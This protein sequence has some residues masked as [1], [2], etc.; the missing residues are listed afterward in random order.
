MALLLA[1]VTPQTIHRPMFRYNRTCYS[2]G[3]S[4]STADEIHVDARVGLE[5]VLGRLGLTVPDL[6]VTARAVVDGSSADDLAAPG[7]IVVGDVITEDA[8]ATLNAAGTPWWDRRG[9][10]HIVTDTVMVHTDNAALLRSPSA[11][12][13]V[14]DGPLDG[15]AFDLAVATLLS[16][17]DPPG[18]REFAR[19]TGRAAS[20][21]SAARRR[22]HDLGLVG[23]DGTPLDTSLF[24]AAAAS[25]ASRPRA[26]LDMLPEP[27]SGVLAVGPAAAVASGAPLVVSGDAAAS[28]LLTWDRREH[29]LLRARHQAEPGHDPVCTLLLADPAWALPAAPTVRTASG[30]RAA[31]PVL[32]AL[33]LGADPARGAEALTG[34]TPEGI[35]RVW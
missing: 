29:T 8:R 2:C 26:R 22:L 32:V 5:A 10:L 28:R 11:P 14:A 9:T 34:W 25:W 7:R 19:A 6:D 17:E 31:H 20:S 24:W 4:R 27:E 18:V 23:A 3:V 16:P 15:V 1:G 21:V 30:H 12:R 33:D 13:S 35:S